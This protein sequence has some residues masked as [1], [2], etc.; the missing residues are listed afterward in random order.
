MGLLFSLSFLIPFFSLFHL[1]GTFHLQYGRLDDA[2]VTQTNREKVRRTSTYNKERKMV[3]VK[4]G[5][6]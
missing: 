2:T 4:L 3:N 1:G 5:K 6:K